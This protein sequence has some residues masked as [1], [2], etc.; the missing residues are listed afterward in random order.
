MTIIGPYHVYETVQIEFDRQ[1][2]PSAPFGGNC[3]PRGNSGGK[4]ENKL[5]RVHHAQKAIKTTSGVGS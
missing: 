3:N 2:G 4:S 5:P 1:I